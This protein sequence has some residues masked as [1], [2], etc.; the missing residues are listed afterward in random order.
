M[1]AGLHIHITYFSV[2]WILSGKGF[3]RILPPLRIQPRL[4]P[5][6]ACAFFALSTRHAPPCRP[7]GVGGDRFYIFPICGS[8]C[9]E[10][11]SLQPGPAR[12][13][14]VPV[15]LLLL[16]TILK[17]IQER[18]FAGLEVSSASRA[19]RARRQQGIPDAIR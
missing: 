14:K 17:Q 4:R 6:Q 19:G 10:E 9:R 16:L 5:P 3:P 2:G 18:V 11:L 1:L 8:L 13:L 15:L 12:C 7:R